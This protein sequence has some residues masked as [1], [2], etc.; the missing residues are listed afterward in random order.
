MLATKICWDL[1]P[2][3]CGISPLCSIMAHLGQGLHYTMDSFIYLFLSLST[4]Y[5]ILYYYLYTMLLYSTSL[6]SLDFWTTYPSAATY[7][8]SFLVLE[9]TP[10][11][12]FQVICKACFFFRI[13][14]TTEFRKPPTGTNWP[15][16]HTHTTYIHTISGNT[17][18]CRLVIRR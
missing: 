12:T 6:I 2:L 3:L 14:T 15:V 7:E 8:T 9:D 5:I 16:T 17:S 18:L 4:T 1:G 13:A 11:T 10:W